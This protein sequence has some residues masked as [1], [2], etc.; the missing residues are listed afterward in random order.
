METLGAVGLLLFVLHAAAHLA[1]VAAV[2][3]AS[4]KRAAFALVLPPVA[5]F[6]A[7]QAGARN[8]VLFYGG[9]LA[10]FTILLVVATY[11]R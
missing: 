9:T 8:R 4:A 11:A 7:W 2:A 5:A 6:W 3:R 1:N 10:L